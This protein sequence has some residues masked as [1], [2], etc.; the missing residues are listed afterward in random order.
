LAV[1]LSGRGSNYVALQEA[2]LRGEVPATVELVLSDV[3]S[4]PG[5]ERA[6]RFG[7]PAVAVPRSPGEDRAAHEQRVLGALA[8]AGVDW[9]CL[10]GYMRILSAGFV[11]RY[12]ARILNVHPSLLPA[13]PGRDSQRQALAY[14][15]KV[16]GC[17]VHLVD[18]GI[19]SGP[20]VAQRAV[21]VRDGETLEE[22]E[23]RILR[24]EHEAYPQALRR[25][26]RERWRLEGR[27]VVFV[28][29]GEGGT[30]A[31][32]DGTLDDGPQSP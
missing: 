3:A 30:A 15:V 26:L 6:R 25:L 1:L 21:S 14:G 32:T 23:R 28:A 2:V 22:L 11:A 7:V 27:R 24:E 8:E 31:A 5:L 9:I 4:A 13:F 20:I 12:P 19:D 10:A 16:A 17:T 18:S 29:P